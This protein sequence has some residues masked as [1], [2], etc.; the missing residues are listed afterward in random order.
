L[1]AGPIAILVVLTAAVLA[2]SRFA[3]ARSDLIAQREAINAE[4]AQLNVAFENR[5]VLIA[6]LVEMVKGIETNQ[7]A[8]FAEV[9]AARSA[10]TGRRAP[11]DKIQASERLSVAL[12]RLLLASENYP[13]LRSAKD[14]LRL[15]EEIGNA[16]S[17]MAIERRKYNEILEHYNA[18]I[19]KFPYN[20]VAG[21]SGFARN[22][23]Y[24]KTAP[25]AL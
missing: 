15:Q 5:A 1:R 7:G 21:L 18:Q 24:F 20:V 6:H 16:D 9:A 14:F 10:L 17:Q 2:G 3:S 19:Q 23:A 4:W 8:V 12:S 25:G 11:Q 22:D 13:K